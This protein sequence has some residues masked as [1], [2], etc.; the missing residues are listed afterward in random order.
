MQH[1]SETFG[2]P[3]SHHP[4]ELCHIERMDYVKA[5]KMALHVGKEVTMIGWLIT[6]KVVETKHGEPMEFVCFEDLT[7]MYEAT[8]FPETYRKFCHLFSTDCGYVLRGLIEQ[9]FGAATVTVQELQVLSMR[10]GASAPRS[11]CSYA[12]RLDT[13]QTRSDSY[14]Y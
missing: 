7:G 14:R 11:Q 1:E 2:F 4:L 6:G 3:L 12:A 9:E 10:H 8:F 5:N 13:G